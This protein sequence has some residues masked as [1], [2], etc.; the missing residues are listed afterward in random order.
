MA[1]QVASREKLLQ[2][3]LFYLTSQEVVFEALLKAMPKGPNSIH[4]DEIMVVVF[5]CMY[6]LSL[7]AKGALFAST[8]HVSAYIGGPMAHQMMVEG[9]RNLI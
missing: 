5:S 4:V 8:I 7:S 9:H 2:F 1:S 6:I 3:Y